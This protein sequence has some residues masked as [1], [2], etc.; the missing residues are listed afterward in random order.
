MSEAQVEQE[1]AELIFEKLKNIG[2]DKFDEFKHD[3]MLDS[4]DY[5]PQTGYRIKGD[6]FS[7]LILYLDGNKQ[8][9]VVR[10]ADVEIYKGNKIIVDWKNFGRRT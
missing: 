5:D 3:S 4:W 8:I 9:D 10:Y 1:Q 7:N 6:G 2:I